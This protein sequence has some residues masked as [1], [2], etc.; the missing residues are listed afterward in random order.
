MILRLPQKLA[1]QGCGWIDEK[2]HQCRELLFRDQ[3]GSNDGGDD[4]ENV[5][6]DDDDDEKTEK[7]IN[8]G[9][10]YI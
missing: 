10:C 5:N 7:V 9:S 6:D 8:A 1:C 2:D 4:D 3:L